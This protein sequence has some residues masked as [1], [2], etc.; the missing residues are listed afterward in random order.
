[1]AKIN[2]CRELSDD[3]L[4]VCT[5]IMVDECK[6]F[7]PTDDSPYMCNGYVEGYCNNIYACKTAMPWKSGQDTVILHG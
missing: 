4:T 5:A 1:M 6:H 2:R 3:G 7:S